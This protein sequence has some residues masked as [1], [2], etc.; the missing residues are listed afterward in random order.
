M[1]ELSFVPSFAKPSSLQRNRGRLRLSRDSPKWR[2]MCDRRSHPAMLL[3]EESRLV[4][5][6]GD[7]VGSQTTKRLSPSL[8]LNFW[9]FF[10]CFKLRLA[11]VFIIV[12]IA[13]VGH[14]CEIQVKYNRKRRAQGHFRMDRAH[15]SSSRLPSSNPRLKYVFPPHPPLSCSQEPF[16]EEQRRLVFDGLWR[17]VVLTCIRSLL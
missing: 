5:W 9:C 15:L 6:E 1:E 17:I 16:R 12:L 11:V 14:I 2:R 7:G 10:I 8:E 3:Q 13:G 4:G